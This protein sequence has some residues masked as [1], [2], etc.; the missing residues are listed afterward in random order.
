MGRRN[1]AAVREIAVALQSLAWLVPRTIGA[2]ETDVLDHLPRTELEVMRL[3]V[4]RPGL[5]LGQVADELVLQP[6]NASSAIRTLI[7]RGLVDRDRG[8]GDRRVIHLYA[9]PKARRIRMLREQAWAGELTE[10]FE[11][12]SDA[13]AERLLAA[14]PALQALADVLTGDLD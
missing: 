4:R 13:D 7:A 6:S 5:T 1:P 12:L 9:T 10:R 2:I 3:L 14:G 8:P 11:L